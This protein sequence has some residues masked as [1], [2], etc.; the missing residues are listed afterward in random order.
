[1]EGMNTIEPVGASRLGLVVPGPRG[2]D[3]ADGLPAWLV[4]TAGGAVDVVDLDDA[5]DRD[6]D[7]YVLLV[8]QYGPVPAPAVE[9]V[10]TRYAVRWAERPMGL[11]AYGGVSRGRDAARRIRHALEE[12]DAVVVDA[13]LGVNV[14][15][16]RGDGGPGAFERVAWELVLDGI[17]QACVERT[18]AR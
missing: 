3:S 1:M 10:V 17:T 5:A 8:G 4:D 11:V 12:L 14:A 15:Q 7:G 9:D 16:V 2:L 13:V 18:T 6:R